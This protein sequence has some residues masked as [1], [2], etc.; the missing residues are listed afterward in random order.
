V[1]VTPLDRRPAIENIE[2]ALGDRTWVFIE[3][4]V[5]KPHGLKTLRREPS[6]AISV[7]LLSRLFLMLRAVKFNDDLAREA[8]EVNH[9][10][11]DR[12]LAA[13]AKSA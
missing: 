4:M 10:S 5:A 13:K 3:Q 6:G 1:W 8:N 9:I 2:N 7:V 12:G 11:P